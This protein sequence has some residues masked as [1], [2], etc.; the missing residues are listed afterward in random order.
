ME[1]KYLSISKL[2]VVHRWS[3]GMDQYVHS[4]LYNGCDY[5][6]MF[7]INVIHITERATGRHSILLNDC[8]FI[9]DV[10]RYV[11]FIHITFFEN[12]YTINFYLW[13]RACKN[14]TRLYLAQN[15]IDTILPVTFWS[16]LDKAIHLFASLIGFSVVHLIICLSSRQ[17]SNLSRPCSYCPYCTD[18]LYKDSTSTTLILHDKTND[19][20]LLVD[21]VKFSQSLRRLQE[22]NNPPPSVARTRGTW[23]ASSPRH[24]RQTREFPPQLRSPQVS[25][26]SRERVTSR[27]T[28][29]LVEIGVINTH[30]TAHEGYI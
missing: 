17:Q 11:L 13:S 25:P 3:L 12:V 21:D 5:P 2:L 9:L 1:S 24:R 29:F 28:S 14:Y 23:Q 8:G 7:R 10:T 16:G 26:T 22:R 20:M 18:R 30:F 6:C 4:T 19:M 15:I 27:L